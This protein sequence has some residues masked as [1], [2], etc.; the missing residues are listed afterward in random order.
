MCVCVCIY[1]YTVYVNICTYIIN[2][3]THKN[4]LPKFWRLED[5]KL[6][7]LGL[8]SISESH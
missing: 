5:P 6:K 3:H 1:I 4:I 7:T 2:I 8:K